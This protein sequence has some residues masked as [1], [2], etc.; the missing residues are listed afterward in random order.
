[1]YSSIH[2]RLHTALGR[3]LEVLCQ[4]NY[5][6]QDDGDLLDDA[7]EV[8]ASRRD[9]ED[10]DDG[11]GDHGVRNS[12]SNT[13]TV[14]IACKFT[15]CGRQ[16][17]GLAKLHPDPSWSRTGLRSLHAAPPEPVAGSGGPPPESGSA[18]I[19]ARL[20]AA[21][22]ANFGLGALTGVDRPGGGR[23]SYSAVAGPRLRPRSPGRHRAAS[24]RRR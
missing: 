12:L 23:C 21:D 1:M 16:W 4:I 14:A 22:G 8:L 9:Y 17:P 15:T 24:G 7:G 18:A 6:Y 3:L 13:R 19:L 10:R 5:M 20:R 11:A 2:A